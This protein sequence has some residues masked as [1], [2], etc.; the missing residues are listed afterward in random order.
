MFKKVFAVLALVLLIS[1]NGNG[2]KS[3][4][5][6]DVAALMDE[7]FEQV[8]QNDFNVIAAYY[9]DKFYENTSKEDWEELYNRIHL[10][11]GQLVSVELKSWNMKSVWGTSGSGKHFTL[12]YNNKYENGNAE[13]TVVLFAPRGK[14]EIKIDGYHYNSKAFL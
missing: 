10:K 12:V 14:N 1:C 5:K 3:L 2:Q 4:S 7:Y 8:K 11:L 13:E 6:D 9:S